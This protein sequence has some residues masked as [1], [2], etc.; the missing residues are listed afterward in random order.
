MIDIEQPST[1]KRGRQNRGKGSA[2]VFLLAVAALSFCLLLDEQ[3]DDDS[4]HRALLSKE[5]MD[6]TS[7]GTAHNSVPLASTCTSQFAKHDG[8]DA[9]CMQ[10]KQWSLP[11]VNDPLSCDVHKLQTGTPSRQ[12]NQ[13]IHLRK[14]LKE[15][16]YQH[17]SIQIKHSEAREI[18]SKCQLGVIFPR[19]LVS[20]CMCGL[21]SD[22]TTT[23][24]YAGKPTEKR[25]W[26]YDY[27]NQGG[28]EIDDAP[29]GRNVLKKTGIYDYDYY[30]KLKSTKFALAPDGDFHWT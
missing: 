26:I 25:M 18:V 20:Y 16:C 14:A 29:N 12:K 10:N 24:Y 22:K 21:W 8:D 6:G 19:S 7:P 2:I 23:Y 28:A 3:G 17:E 9:N 5:G 27:E 30:D 15:E 1:T 4:Y 13:E 11:D